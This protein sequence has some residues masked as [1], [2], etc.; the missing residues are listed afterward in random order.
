[1]N[2]KNA[3]L[4]ATP[5]EVINEAGS[6]WWSVLTKREMFAMNAPELPDWF[7]TKWG[8]ENKNNDTYFNN[9]SGSKLVRHINTN[10]EQARY[11]AWRVE[12]AET[13]LKTLAQ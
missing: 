8:N 5:F 3:D 7:E 13:L 1:M 6:R 11:F 12:Y 4:P 2:T 10:G 9:V